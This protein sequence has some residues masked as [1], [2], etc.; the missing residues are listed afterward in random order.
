M[1]ELE[2]P[3][4]NP[5]KDNRPNVTESHYAPPATQTSRTS[6][7][8]SSDSHTS[9]HNDCAFSYANHNNSYNPTHNRAR[10]GWGVLGSQSERGAHRLE[11]GQK[12]AP[13]EHEHTDALKRRTG[14]QTAR[15]LNKR[16]IRSVLPFSHRRHRASVRAQSRER[17]G[18]ETEE[19]GERARARVRR[20]CVRVTIPASSTI[21]LTVYF[22]LLLLQLPSPLPLPSS[23]PV[24]QAIMISGINGKILGS[25][26]AACG[27]QAPAIPKAVV[28]IVCDRRR[29]GAKT[30]S[31][32]RKSVESGLLFCRTS[33][34]KLAEDRRR[35][36]C[37]TNCAAWPL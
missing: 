36:Q 14:S 10:G 24:S 5:G 25:G 35:A 30:R 31:W 3:K 22:V 26:P 15:E 9:V 19:R 29:P 37:R 32:R 4:I 16:T 13:H 28:M 27:M 1:Q 18:G 21:C 6:A 33:S 12:Q 8:T 11:H 7:L 20:A 2:A 17:G 34:N 23:P